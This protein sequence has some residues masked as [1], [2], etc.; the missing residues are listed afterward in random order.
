SPH[1]TLRRRR[2]GD[3]APYQRGAKSSPLREEVSRGALKH[4]DVEKETVA[5]IGKGPLLLDD[6]VIEEL[7]R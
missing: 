6:I 4:S 5:F 7:G 3:I 2:Y 1:P